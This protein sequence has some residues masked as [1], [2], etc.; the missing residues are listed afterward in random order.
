MSDRAPTPCTLAGPPHHDDKCVTFGC[1][2]CIYATKRAR[3]AAQRAAAERAGEHALAWSC[4]AEIQD[5]A[6]GHAAWE[7]T[8][9]GARHAL[10]RAR[11]DLLMERRVLDR[12]K[13]DLEE[14][15][16]RIERLRDDV[17]RC[18]AR[19]ADAE[20]EVVRLEAAAT[21][22]EARERSNP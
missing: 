1:V 15:E 5:L 22:E 10:A 8:K 13:G 17:P 7:E 20:R 11:D 21:A 12:A 18:A 19:V 14:A 2:C 4:D 9:Y 3:L 16:A 6:D